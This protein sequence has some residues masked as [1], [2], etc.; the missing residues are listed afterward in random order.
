[1]RRLSG[2]A[3]I[4]KHGRAIE[5]RCDIAKKAMSEGELPPEVWLD[6]KIKLDRLITLDERC[7]DALTRLADGELSPDAYVQLVGE[8]LRAQKLWE[9]RHEKVFGAAPATRS[10]LGRLLKTPDSLSVDPVS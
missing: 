3:R 9:E 10:A 7:R 6:L 1:M 8:Q 2:T 4:E 5:N